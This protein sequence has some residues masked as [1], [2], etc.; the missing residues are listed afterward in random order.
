MPQQAPGRTMIRF[1]LANK[2]AII[3]LERSEFAQWQDEMIKQG[4]RFPTLLQKQDV[5][6]LDT[7]AKARAFFGLKDPVTDK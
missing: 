7:L 6:E 3:I 4:K 1:V 2:P 5:P